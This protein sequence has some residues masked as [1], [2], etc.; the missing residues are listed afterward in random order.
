[1]TLHLFVKLTYL[2]Y[3]FAAKDS[4]GIPFTEVK[5]VWRKRRR[6]AKA[7]FPN[8]DTLEGQQGSGVAWV[9]NARGKVKYCA[10]CQTC[11]QELIHGTRRVGYKFRAFIL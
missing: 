7:K 1:M 3:A 10:P 9:V 11:G 5:R 6:H 2:I 4:R 8:L